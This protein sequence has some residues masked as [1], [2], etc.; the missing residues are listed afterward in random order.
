AGHSAY[1][2]PTSY[3]GFFAIRVTAAFPVHVSPPRL[4]YSVSV[5]S[6]TGTHTRVTPVGLATSTRVTASNF[7]HGFEVV[8]DSAAAA[9]R[10]R[11]G[12]GAWGPGRPL[13]RLP[14]SIS[15]TRDVP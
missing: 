15:K 11:G 14:S 6:G 8:S 1:T 12:G 9:S 13:R 4:K 2:R 7:R 5:S 3:L 10:G